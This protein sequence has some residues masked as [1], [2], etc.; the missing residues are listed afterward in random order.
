METYENPMGWAAVKTDS[1][2]P[3]KL[4]EI[5]DYYTYDDASAEF[6][7]KLGFKSDK[8]RRVSAYVEHDGVIFLPREAETRFN[9][10][11]KK[12]LFV[13]P[14]GRWPGGC[15]DLRANQ[16]APWEALNRNPSDQIL[17]LGCGRGKTVMA[18]RYGYVHDHKML[19]IVDRIELAEQWER[20]CIDLFG[21]PA[22]RVGKVY[23]GKFSIGD[24]VTIT[25]FQSLVAL[26]D[27]MDPSFWSHFSL[28]VVDEC[29][30]AAAPTFL[31]VLPLFSGEK[32]GL[33]A[34]PD[35]K[36]GLDPLFKAHIGGGEYCYVDT[37]RD[38]AGTYC[39]VP[40]HALVNDTQ[41]WACSRKLRGVQDRDG[42]PVYALMRPKYYSAACQNEEWNNMIA[43]DIASA[44]AKGRG[45]LVLAETKA[46]IDI[47]GEKLD[48]LGVP[49]GVMTSAVNRKTRR[50]SLLAP[51]IL[52]TP[53]LCGKGLDVPH[54]DTLFLLCPHNDI[55]RLRQEKG[56]IDGRGREGKKPPLI[57]IYSHEKVKQLRKRANQMAEA[58]R[59]FEPE[60]Q[61]RRMER[62]AR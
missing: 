23:A 28:V 30:V 53:Q 12:S 60:A 19:V 1:L 42:N 24:A 26:R 38:V 48:A 3:E 39:F 25:T 22:D 20:A 40:L 36:D 51:V 37:T 27:R 44:I 55:G 5:R 8:P 29:H 7:D 13:E 47:I 10:T 57:V 14:S 33:S 21:I 45:C 46:H 15:P 16:E 4:K 43:R 17:V 32:L 61:I 35:R 52:S 59:E 11:V 54:L 41:L 34:T 49:F 50:E 56:R 2:S 9:L 18:L 6:N 58:I 62:K 31:T